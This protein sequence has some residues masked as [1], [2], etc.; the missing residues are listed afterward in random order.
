M[1]KLTLSSCRSLI[2]FPK[3]S[4]VSILLLAITA[5]FG[6]LL[7]FTDKETEHAHTHASHVM[8]QLNTLQ[9]NIASLQ[10]AV[11]KPL[12]QINLDEMTRQIQ[13]VSQQLEDVRSQNS[14]YFNQALSKTEAALATR[15]DAIQQTL[16]RLDKKHPRITYLKPNDLPFNVIGLDSIQ[17]VA[18]ASIAYNFK[19]LPLEKGDALAGWRITRIDYGKQV[20]E[21]ENTKKQ[22][23][24]LTE[25]YIGQSR[26]S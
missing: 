8:S 2:E 26:A 9:T 25:Q 17:Q 21:F 12:P 22:H 6:A 11:S 3:H 13:Q 7:I 15:L 5:I 19:T 20:I 24:L 10:E 16:H 1:N 23:V 18:V 4:I 14:K